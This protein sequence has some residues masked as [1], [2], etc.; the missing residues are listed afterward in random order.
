M[1]IFKCIVSF[2][3]HIIFPI[4]MPSNYL[5]ILDPRRS[6]RTDVASVHPVEVDSAQGC[7][8]KAVVAAVSRSP[9]RKT[10]VIFAEDSGYNLFFFT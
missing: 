4:H 8:R 5:T 1:P 2:F 3:F 6:T 9:K 10:V 7:S